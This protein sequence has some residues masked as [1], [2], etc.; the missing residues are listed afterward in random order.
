[1]L[2]ERKRLWRWPQM[3]LLVVADQLVPGPRAFS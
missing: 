3:M 1:M 2:Q